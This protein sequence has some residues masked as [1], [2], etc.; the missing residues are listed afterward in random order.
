MNHVMAVS[1]DADV[2]LRIR[3]LLEPEGFAVTATR[4]I[5][6]REP[7]ADLSETDLYIIDIDTNVADGLNQVRQLRKQSSIG[8]IVLSAQDCE[9][10]RVA[11]FEQGA[12]DYISTPLR[13]LEFVARVKAVCRRCARRRLQPSAPGAGMVVGGYRLVPESRTVLNMRGEEVAL[14]T[15]E[16]NIFSVLAYH[17]G[18]VLTRDEIIGLSKGRDWRCYERSV[19]GLVSRLRRK[20][21]G[22]AGVSHFIKTVHGTGYTIARI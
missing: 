15:A 6:E 10:S 11:G 14:T 8:I 13:P 19:D 9:A 4:I 22:R 12:D 17:Q 16:Y 18:A 1:T 2:G 20:L 7:R 21:P 5:T 3:R